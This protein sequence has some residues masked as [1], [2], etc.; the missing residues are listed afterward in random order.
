MRF[1]DLAPVANASMI[2]KLP[3]LRVSGRIFLL[4]SVSGVQTN[5]LSDLE[6]EAKIQSLKSKLHPETLI[7]VLSSTNDLNSSLR[8]FKWASLQNQFLHT[9]DTYYHIIIKLGMASRIDEMEGFCNEMVKAGFSASEQALL[10]LIDS[11]IM[12]HRFDEALRV[13]S[14]LNSNSYKPS[15][16]LINRLLGVL[17][18]ERKGIKSV[19]FIYKE[20]VKARIGPTAETL[21]HLMEALFDAD[22]V[23]SVLDQYK[24][25]QKKGCCPNSTAYVVMVSG[26]IGKNLLDKA[27]VVLNEVLES[28]CD[29]ESRF[30]SHI[31]P[32]LFK[33][34][35]HEMGLKLFEKMKSS[36][37]VPDLSVYEVLIQYFARNLYM[38]DAINLLNEMIS[39]DLKPSD[40]VFVD[41]V[42]GFCMLNKLSEA[43]Q[44][45]EDQ[46]ITEADAYNALLKG[47]C[48]AGN[49]A[50]VMWLFQKMVEK[51]I[52]NSLSSN[53]LISYLSENQSY[54]IV[55]KALS[56]LIAS[57]YMPNS[58]TYSALIIGKCKS[59][60]VDDALN[61]FHH[62]C[63]ERW[64]VDSSCYDTLIV[65]LCQMNK[66][67][68]A[69]DVFHYILSNK[70]T[71][72][73][74]SFSM[75]VKGL[76]L[77]GKVNKVINL[78]RLASN[79]GLSCS[80]EDY[81]IIMKSMSNLS[82][83]NNL[84]IIFGKMVIEGCP[85]NSET[86]KQL[87]KSMSEHQRSTEYAMYLNRMVDEGLLPDTEILL[88]SLSFLAQKS[89]L[90]I[91]LPT[92]QKLLYVSDHGV[93]NHAIYNI[94]ITG[95]GK[96]GI[97]IK[98]VCYWIGCW[99]KVGYPILQ[100]IGY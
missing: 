64:V 26:L 96:K 7:N 44:F 53:I 30:F 56:R 14:V 11:F 18:E 79:S 89:Q 72:H 71:V 34:N 6:Y 59:N 100:P 84:L 9:T 51:N 65:S 37:I 99:K 52:T 1:N 57:G 28:G 23:D 75:L 19:L 81:S 40:C 24:R 20:M 15:I 41:L 25:M 93:L 63:E 8:L 47:Y 2:V 58:T 68:D 55:Y 39:N 67:Q 4:S 83:C 78:L 60:E 92:I 42:N 70:F 87:I 86:Y 17:V 88:N 95:F 82:K 12:L 90:H 16:A 61:L 76:C 27:L 98:P 85:I 21:N 10:R 3:Y 33:M 5:H 73:A 29:L 22:R 54:D 80:N 36:N 35:R 97:H 77:K 13:F 49:Y 48:Q 94:L 43:K 32:L 91:V 31:L 50:E 38:D 66:I 74:S 69:I 62:V 45:L 46:Q